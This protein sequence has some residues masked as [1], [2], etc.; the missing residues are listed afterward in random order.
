MKIMINQS[1]FIDFS[2]EM[3]KN[4]PAMQEIRVQSLHWEDPQER[5]WLPTPVFLPGESHGQRSLVGYSPWSHKEL[6]T[7]EQLTLCHFRDGER[8]LQ[9]FSSQPKVIKAVS[10]ILRF[11]LFW[12]RERESVC[13]CVCVCWGHGM[14]WI[15]QRLHSLKILDISLFK[16]IQYRKEE[17]QGETRGAQ[18]H[19]P[20]WQ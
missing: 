20:S 18:S 2:L 3:G 14:V 16:F 7:T 5:E 17:N 1:I 4:L 8:G 13:V 6:D 19:K 15:K 10:L 12:E 9:R 11:V